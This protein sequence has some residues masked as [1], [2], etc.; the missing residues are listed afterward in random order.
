MLLLAREINKEKRKASLDRSFKNLIIQIMLRKPFW[1]PRRQSCFEING[2][3]YI[4]GHIHMAVELPLHIQI[5][6][7]KFW[8]CIFY[9][10]IQAA[11]WQ[12]PNTYCR[13]KQTLPTSERPGEWPLGAL[14]QVTM[15]RPRAVGWR[16][17]QRLL[18]SPL[19]LNILEVVA[20]TV[21]HTPEI[22]DDYLKGQGNMAIA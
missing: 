17:I 2:D 20:N 15:E 4:L 1:F 7:M 18:H 8:T 5:H 16:K 13:E 19:L 9:R 6:S 3:Y 22:E 10:K 11:S 21:R 12:S 14:V